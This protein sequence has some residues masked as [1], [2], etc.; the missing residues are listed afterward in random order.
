MP[1]PVPVS[2]ARLEALAREFGT[3]LQLY[4]EAGIRENAREL[5]SAFSSCQ[6]FRQFFAVKA[7][8]SPA[9]LQI[10]VQEGCGLDCS[11]TAE[12]H[13]ASLLGVP[14]DRIMY[15]SNYTS[16]KDLEVAF[17]QG[18][19]INLDD[20]SL[21]TSLVEARGRCPELIS[22]RLNPGLGRTDSETASNV[23]G[24]PSAKFGLPPARAVAAYR[25]ARDAGATRFGI[26][27]MTG[28]CVMNV[29]YWVRTGGVHSAMARHDPSPRAL[30]SPLAAAARDC[31]RPHGHG[32]SRPRRTG[33]HVRVRQRRRRHRHPLP[34]NASDRRCH[35]GP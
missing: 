19:I 32:R 14:G 29:E 12:L 30:R 2:P 13:I 10:L 9:I 17:D 3:P 26:H 25:S 11:S 34:T 27:M 22:F 35:P 8:P 15:T 31:R 16:K 28:S 18:V 4:S 6:G 5:I 7:L 21:V 23:L 24:G 20:E 1:L 33:H